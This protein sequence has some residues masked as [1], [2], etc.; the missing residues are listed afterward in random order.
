MKMRVLFY[1]LKGGNLY[2]E[3]KGRVGNLHALIW[4]RTSHK[5]YPRFINLLNFENDVRLL[6]LTATPRSKMTLSMH[7][8]IMQNGV[9][10]RLCWD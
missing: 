6:P 4:S 2:K 10:S 3:A 9:K 8:G 7:L 1:G 5:F